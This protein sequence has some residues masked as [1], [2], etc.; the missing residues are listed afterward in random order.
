DDERPARDRAR[1]GR[2]GRPRE[3]RRERL[4]G[5]GPRPSGL[6][7]SSGDAPRRA[8]APRRLPRGRASLGPGLSPGCGHRPIGR[9]LRR[10]TLGVIALAL[11]LAASPAPAWTPPLGIPAPPFGIQE[12]APPLPDPWTVEVPK[13]YYV[14][15]RTGRDWLR[16]QDTPDAP[17]ATIPK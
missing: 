7:A 6:R 1:G 12:A 16:G 14:D 17:R 3:G 9:D 8:G 2:P 13:F 5:H 4:R 15:G 11:L 10:R